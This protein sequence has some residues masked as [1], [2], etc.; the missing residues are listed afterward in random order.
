M[1]RKEDGVDRVMEKQ[2]IVMVGLPRSGKTTYESKLQC[3]IVSPD[4]VRYALHGQAF[5]ADAEEMVWAISKYMAKALF[6]AGHARV[7]VD[8]TNTTRKRRDFWKSGTWKRDFRVI[9]T[10]RD[11]CIKRAH[12]DGRPELVPIIERMV[13]Q[14][15]PVEAETDELEVG[16]SC[17]PRAKL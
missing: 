4:A 10:S 5:V 2:L 3:P 12:S 16:E 8:A 1:V 11:E 7:V 6:I 15:E 17:N 14:F 9:D 13:A